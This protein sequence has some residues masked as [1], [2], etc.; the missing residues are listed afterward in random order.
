MALSRRVL[1]MFL[2]VTVIASSLLVRVIQATDHTEECSDGHGRDDENNRCR[3]EEDNGGDSDSD[4]ED[5][6]GHQHDDVED[7]EF[8]DTYKI[9]NNVK[10]S[11][12]VHAR[13]A[14][15]FRSSSNEEIFSETKY[16]VMGH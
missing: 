10:I 6:A 2:L 11:N 1:L 14:S 13:M 16:V 12:P 4:D 7:D 9:V 3:F 15:S 8:D 5:H